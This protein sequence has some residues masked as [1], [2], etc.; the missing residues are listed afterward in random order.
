MNPI[1]I[2]TVFILQDLEEV[3][4]VARIGGF[5]TDDP[6]DPRL[7]WAPAA[8]EEN[9]GELDWL[10]NIL[11]FKSLLGLGRGV[12]TLIT[13]MYRELAKKAGVDDT[14]RPSQVWVEGLADVDLDPEGGSDAPA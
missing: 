2:R 14:I 3:G 12:S 7:S 8:W 10:S 5:T 4:L 11:P 6:G 9:L 13:D 1:H